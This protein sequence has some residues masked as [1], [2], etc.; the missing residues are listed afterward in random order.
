MLTNFFGKSS[1]INFIVL[2]ALILLYF[3]LSFFESFST[4]TFDF[5]FILKQTGKFGLTLLYCFV[6][7]F[8]L[9]K[10]KL[11]L[12]NSYG[13]LIL[14]TLFGV[15]LEVF[16]DWQTLF[17][18]ILLLIY[19][20]KIL[21]FRTTKSLYEKLFDGGFWLSI[22]FILEPFSLIFGILIYLAVSL[23]QKTNYQT[24]LI[25]VIGFATPLII[26]F[27]YCFWSDN[28]ERF[29]ELFYWYSFYDIEIY[30]SNQYSIPLLLIGVFSMIALIVKTPKIFLI[31]GSY[32]KYWII[33][34]L[35]FLLSIIYLSLKNSKNGSELLIAFF[36]VSIMIA[37][38]IESIQRKYMKEIVVLLFILL[39]VIFVIV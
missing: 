20:R 23:F 15:F 7:G 13:F 9:S 22:L 6:F 30:L 39:P 36:P 33:I 2:F 16:K 38:W 29:Y 3:C 31:S 28:M 17:F 1:P 12:D 5:D 19:L 14:V 35:I 24:I 10:N 8:I 32:R 18:N 26:Y 4:L 37:N 21:S 27:T 34:S 11:T 25:P